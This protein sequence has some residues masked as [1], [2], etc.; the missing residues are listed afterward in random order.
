L[1]FNDSLWIGSLYSLIESDR[2]MDWRLKQQL[3]M[4]TA[5]GLAYL[6]SI[7]VVHRWVYIVCMQFLYSP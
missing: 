3:M 4:D 2:S 6:H 5:Q 7:G 1:M